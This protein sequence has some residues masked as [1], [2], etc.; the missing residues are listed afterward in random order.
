MHSYGQRPL[1]S[2]QYRFFRIF[3]ET[4]SAN[5][6]RRRL[7]RRHCRTLAAFAAF[8]LTLALAPGALSATTPPT[9]S[10]SATSA[11]FGAVAVGTKNKQVIKLKKTG[12]SNLVLSSATISG[13]GFSM[14]DRKSTRLNSSHV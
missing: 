11:S 5:A 6:Q 14:R 1:F 2:Q 10:V 4:L 7:S 12:G 8:T 3:Q 13:T 9:L